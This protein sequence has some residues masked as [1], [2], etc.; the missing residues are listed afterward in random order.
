MGASRSNSERTAGMTR[1]HAN[2]VPGVFI[3]AGPW[4]TVRSCAGAVRGASR[5]LWSAEHLLKAGLFRTRLELS[6]RRPASAS[7]RKASERVRRA[8]DLE[9]NDEVAAIARSLDGASVGVRVNKL[10]GRHLLADGLQIGD[11]DVLVVIAQ[12]PLR[13]RA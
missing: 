5:L 12:G 4:P 6:G 13:A 9:F 8:D 11:I 3:A 7:L 1:W 10:A 2:T